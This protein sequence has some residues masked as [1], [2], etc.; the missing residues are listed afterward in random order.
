MLKELH[1]HDSALQHGLDSVKA[2]GGAIAAVR[3]SRGRS[4]SLP[5][6]GE[7]GQSLVELAL[8]FPILLMI[9]TGIFAFGIAFYNQLQLE[10]AV[11][12][13]SRYLQQ[14]RNTTTDPCAD[15][16][17]A[18]ENAAPSLTPSQIPQ[19]IFRRRRP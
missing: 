2:L 9:L 13:G 18:I 4:R 3:V 8:V 5:R 11:D 12:A 1:E 6:F 17:A 10:S 7:E 15:V 19:P 14:I 16:F